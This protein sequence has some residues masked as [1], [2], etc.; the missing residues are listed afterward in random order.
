MSDTP[1]DVLVAGY[2]RVGAARQDYD[3]VVELVKAKQV[4]VEGVIL[5]A[6]DESGEVTVLSTGDH[7][8]RK[9]LGWGAGSAWWSGCSRPSSSRPSRWVP[10]VGRSSAG[11]SITG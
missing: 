10:R 6:H 4:N 2:Q 5:V 3:A 8:G 9:G 1:M 7:L 11:S